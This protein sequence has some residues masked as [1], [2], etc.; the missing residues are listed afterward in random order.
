M[1]LACRA[2]VSIPLVF[3][4][5]EINGKQYIDGG[6]LDNIPTKYFKDNE[7]EFNTKEVTDDIEEIIL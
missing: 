7:P 1:A 5:V 2:S 6:Y 3:E 4:P